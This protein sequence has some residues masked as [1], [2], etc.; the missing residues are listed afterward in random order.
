MQ[1]ERQE[2]TLRSFLQ[3]ALGLVSG[4]RAPNGTRPYDGAH[5]LR[6]ADGFLELLRVFEARSS[7]KQ[8]EALRCC[9]LEAYLNKKR[10]TQSPGATRRG[11]ESS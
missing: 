9:T 3:Q 7:S 11:V 1:D 5:K 4:P 6:E 8:L 10:F 2:R